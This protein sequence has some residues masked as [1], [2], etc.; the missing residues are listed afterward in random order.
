MALK[1]T[2]NTEHTVFTKN[3]AYYYDLVYK[4]KPYAEECDFVEKLMQRFSKINDETMQKSTQKTILD[5]GCGTGR[6]SLILAQR[7][8][9]VTGTD[10]SA[11]MIALAKK[12]A[13]DA[14]VNVDFH[15]M[16]MQETQLDRQ[17]D[18]IIGM[19]HVFGYLT[20]YQ[21]IE[22]M[23]HKTKE[24]MHKDSLLIL[25]FWNG[26]MVLKDTWPQKVKIFSEIVDRVPTRII[27]FSFT[28]LDTT[29]N[30]AEVRF[31]TLVLEKH[32]K[33]G[34]SSTQESTQETVI[35]EFEETHYLRYF[36]PEEIKNYLQAH[37][38]EVLHLCPFLD[39]DGSTDKLQKVWSGTI[40]AKIKN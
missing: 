15:V 16:P 37:G 12:R 13:S 38:F 30:I 22:K 21:D 7:G 39:V 23:L 24:H 32:A 1:N 35:N 4:D 40:V 20:D 14:R 19:F 5:L 2:Q 9:Q 18:V 8:Y 36:F 10:L 33:P 26:E 3:Y 31:Q 6:Y 25:D 27:R 34:A 29:K 11:D 17:F 28:Q